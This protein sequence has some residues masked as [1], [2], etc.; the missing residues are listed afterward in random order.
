MKTNEEDINTGTHCCK[1]TVSQNVEASGM[2]DFISD[3]FIQYVNGNLPKTYP[4]ETSEL[5]R[6][7]F[8]GTLTSEDVEPEFYEQSTPSVEGR[9]EQ[10]VRHVLKGPRV[11]SYV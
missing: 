8:D 1:E 2:L 7:W 6:K 10:F 9:A 4:E 3:I 11:D 5:L